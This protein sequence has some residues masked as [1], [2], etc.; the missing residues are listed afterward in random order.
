MAKSRSEGIIHIGAVR[1]RVTGSGNLRL[2][3]YSYQQVKSQVLPVLPMVA[4]TDV[5]PTKLTN[6]KNQR[7]QVEFRVNA[8]NETF[9]ISRI[10]PFI[11]FVATSYPQ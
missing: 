2:T 10:I 5:Q 8:I 4:S 6:F 7:I 3:L 9:T 1:L 11:Q